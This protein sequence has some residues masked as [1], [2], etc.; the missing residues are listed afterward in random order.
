LQ[1]ANRHWDGNDLNENGVKGEI[2]KVFLKGDMIMNTSD[3]DQDLTDVLHRINDLI[4]MMSEKELRM[5][6]EELEQRVL[7]G[8]RE[9]HR[10]PFF[11]YVD[12]AD[13]HGAY[14]DFIQ[15]IS[16]GGVFIQTRMPFSVGQEVSLTFP[17]PNQPENLKI[18]GNIVRIGE[19]GI[20]V[21]FMVA[22]DHQRK[23]VQTLLE[24]I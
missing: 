5:L 23:M 17:I 9:H 1:G 2:I 16:S 11:T 22:D 7:K 8:R 3:T 21:Q 18:P 24:I 13:K 6:L 12:Y 20:G 14:R 4:R 10:K 19:E 15:D